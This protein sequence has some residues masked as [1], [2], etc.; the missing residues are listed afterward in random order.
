MNAQQFNNAVSALINIALKDGVAKRQMNTIEL[1]EILAGNCA[2]V[3][4]IASEATRKPAEDDKKA[5]EL[6]N[7]IIP[8]PKNFKLPPG[9]GN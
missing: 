5:K 2:S 9:G 1:C 3:L 8:F 4:R 7:I 6:T